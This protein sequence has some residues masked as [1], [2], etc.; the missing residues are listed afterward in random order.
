MNLR[1]CVRAG[2]AKLA[3][4]RPEEPAEAF[5]RLQEAIRNRA[6]AGDMDLA[7]FQPGAVRSS[8]E[9]RLGV[10]FSEYLETMGVMPVLHAG[11]KECVRVRPED[12]GTFLADYIL[13]R[14]PLPEYV[15]AE[16]ELAKGADK[17]LKQLG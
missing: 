12:P 11:M 9:G 1:P 16:R 14:A 6:R 13:D 7:S 5:G 2:L 15:I 8:A 3:A 17:L 4:L 10:P